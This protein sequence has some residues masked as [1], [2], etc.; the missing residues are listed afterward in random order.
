LTALLRLTNRLQALQWYALHRWLIEAA[1]IVSPRSAALLRELVAIASKRDDTK[2]AAEACRRLLAICP[3]DDH[4]LEQLAT[5]DLIEGNI[6]AAREA[7]ARHPHTQALGLRLLTDSYIDVDRA[8]SQGVYVACLKNVDVETTYWSIL[9]DTRVYNLEVHNR[10]LRKSP[11]VEGR[12]APDNSAFLYKVPRVSK[13]IESPCVH[14]GGDHN[15]CHWITHNMLKLALLEGTP[16]VNLPL[17]INEDL[18]PHQ[19]AY[20][21]L[22]GIADERLIKLPPGALVSCRELIVPT[23]VVNHLKMGVGTQWLRRKVMA[24]METG[25]ATDLLFVSRR[26]AKV[27]RV[28]NESEV[29]AKLLALGFSSVV[30]GEMSVPDQIRRFSRAR[31][32]VGAH[33]A[34]FGNLVFCAPGTHVIEMNSTYKSHIPDFT[35]LARIGEL[36]LTTVLSDEYDFTRAEPYYPDTDFRADV[37]KVIGAVRQAAPELFA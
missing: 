15:Y 17:L 24:C 26:D 11:F 37:V 3:D 7:L 32:V 4:A 21:E 12:A 28:I 14:L 34:A 18:R 9:D 23:N 1:L 31:V 2:L 20:L 6:A 33:G 35:F 29:E 19:R 27:R 8:R 10:G 13:I 5:F 36:K 16:H 30:P 25:P 22:L